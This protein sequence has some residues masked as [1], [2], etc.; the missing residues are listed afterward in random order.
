MAAF[1]IGR[2][3]QSILVL[4]VMSLIIFVGVFAIGDPIELLIDPMATQAD[5]DA[6]AIALGLDL[7]LWQ[8]YLTFLW[9]AFHLD[10]GRSFVI[11]APAMELIFQRMP[12]TIEL[13]VAALLIAIGLGIPLGIVAA[14]CPRSVIGKGIMASSILGFSLPSFWVGLMLIMTFSVALGWLP[15]NG[16]GQTV[17]VLGIQWSIFTLDGLSHLIL[18][19]INLSL[20]KLSLI[21]RLTRAGMREVLTTD[22]V[23]FARAKGLSEWRVVGVHALRNTLIPIVTIIGLEFGSLLAGAIVTESVFSWPGIGQL[24]INSI[25]LLDRPVIVA[26]M[27]IVLFIFILINLAIDI[28]YSIIDPRIRLADNP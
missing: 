3:G 2:I 16:R 8:Q 10:L 6:A 1:I 24:M 23:R 26:Y 18:P 13:T 5:R 22:Y 12:A 28:I 4:L 19:A 20:F 11:P 27:I 15:S 25:F 9:R 7:P 14:L 21:I 17:E